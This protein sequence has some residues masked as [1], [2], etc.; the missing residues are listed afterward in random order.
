MNK[1]PMV[2]QLTKDEQEALLWHWHDNPSL[3]LVYRTFENFV[4]VR[5]NQ[6]NEKND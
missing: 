2:T 5:S 6:F 4:A 3:Q 1:Q